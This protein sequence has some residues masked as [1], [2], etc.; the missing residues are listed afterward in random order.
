MGRTVRR[1]SP[2][3]SARSAPSTPACSASAPSP[4][5]SCSPF[6]C[7]APSATTATATPCGPSTSSRPR[8]S[9]RSP[10][11]TRRPP[12]SSSSR[13]PSTPT[14]PVT[15]TCGDE[16]RRRRRRAD[17]ADD[18][19][20]DDAAT[21]PQAL[22]ATPD[23]A[24]QYTAAAGDY[25]LRIADGSGTSLDSL[26]EVNEATA[27]TPIYPGSTICLPE[28]A[29]DAGGLRGVRQRTS[30]SATRPAAQP[31]WRLRRRRA[32]TSTSR[33]PATTGCA[34]PTPP[35]SSSM[36]CSSSTTPR[37]TRRCTPAPRCACRPVPSGRRRRPP[38][39]R[40]R[41][42][43]RRRQ[44][45][46][47]DAADDCGTGDDRRRRRPTAGDDG[48]ADDG[49]AG[50]AAPGEIEQIIRDVVARRPRG[51][52]PAHRLAGEQLQPAGAEL[53]AARACS[54]STT[55]STP[56]GSPSSA[57][58]PSRTSTTRT[59]TPRRPTPCTS[60]P[61]AGSRGG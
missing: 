27:E 50:A 59:P 9:R 46:D 21:G 45:R 49:A 5:P 28:G 31:R 8:P 56:A 39:R 57:S 29:A 24:N 43:R 32:P 48:G 26:L 10:H 12:M 42:H 54:R 37:R 23:C 33:W 20:S 61:A 3:G 17:D 30:S 36:S 35:G 7:S 51:A 18:A 16:Q 22:S 4:S 25:W 40:P 60:A 13:R 14:S 19:T 1:G 2:N 34:S 47:H 11:R 52:G 6:R 55:T 53:T 58:T 44:H 15:P 41:R 38:P